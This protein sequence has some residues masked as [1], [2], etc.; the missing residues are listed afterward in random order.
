MKYIKKESGF[1]LIELMIVI[2]I[3][4]ILAAIAVPAYGEHVRKGRIQTAQNDLHTLAANIETI[5]S[6]QLSY[7]PAGKA[8]EGWLSA[9]GTDFTFEVDISSGG[10]TINATGVHLSVK[11]CNMSLDHKNKL[12]EID[13]TTICKLD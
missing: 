9:S 7:P 1:T 12:K 4:G 13:D 11:G 10:F 3:I 2:A 5:Y 6:R 8:K